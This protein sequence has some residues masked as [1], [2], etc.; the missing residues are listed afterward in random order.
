MMGSHNNIYLLLHIFLRCVEMDNKTALKSDLD[1]NLNFSE[2][3]ILLD[4]DKIIV[5][6][7]KRT[8]FEL[9]INEIKSASVEEGIGIG[10]LVIKTKKNKE[11][12]I[13]YFTKKKAESF[14]KLSL[15]INAMIDGKDP[16]QINLDKKEEEYTNKVG[17]L[18]WLIH[19]MKPYKLKISLGVV[20]AL[21]SVALNL[22]P[23]LIIK[24][25]IDNVLISTSDV[26]KGLFGLLTLELFAALAGVTLVSILQNYILTVTGQKVVNDL[27]SRTYDHVMRLS[28]SSIEKISSGRILSRLTTDVGNTQWLMVWGF[29]TIA[30]NVL[31]ILGVGLILFAMDAN[32]AVFILIPV[33]AAIYAL[34][35]YRK[36]SHRIYHRNWRRN[37]DVT[38]AISDTVP[39]YFI[40]KSF[41]KEKFE[42]KRL[43][44]LLNSLYDSQVRV[45]KMNQ[46]YWPVLGFITAFST[47]LIWWVGGNQVIAGSIQLGVITAFVFYMSMF[48]GPINNLSNIIPFIQQASTSGDRLRE[49]LETEPTIT[50]SKHPRKPDLNAGISFNNVNFGYEP[51][52][53]VL[54]NINLSIAKGEKVAIVGKSGSGKSTISKLILRF[55]D[56]NDGAMSINGVN[57]KEIE[58]GYLRDRIAYVPQD[59]ILFDNTVAYNVAYGSNNH[60][61]AK[62]IIAACKAAIIHD[63]IMKLPSAYDTNLNER[64]SSLSG[65]QKQRISIA[66]AVVKIPDIVILDE[67]TSNLDVNSE[68]EIY[69]ALVNLMQG[70]TSIMITHNAHEVMN[71]DRI[72]VMENG[73]ICESGSPEDLLRKKGNF[74][75]MFKRQISKGEFKKE[76]ADE[77]VSSIYSYIDGFILDPKRITIT[78]GDRESIVDVVALGKKHS[79]LLPKLPF[80]ISNPN[81]VI[82]YKGGNELLFVDDITALDHESYKILRKAITMNNFKPAI[83]TIRKILIRGDELEWHVGTEY[84][85]TIINTKG[86]RNISI[87]GSTISLTDTF[88]NIYE[89]EIDKLD[90]KSFSI[91]SESI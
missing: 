60:I 69:K 45:T 2:E 68:R 44:A 35:K 47:I 77:S 25:L 13:A 23:P 1:H 28:S 11:L 12:E 82:F 42:N 78:T 87:D 29:P 16:P 43:S 4:K 17:T 64:G 72:I 19:F 41:S 5:A 56:V 89:I 37:A 39:N 66:R 3:Q 67:S 62:E 61:G 81:A 34:I 14:R 58:L 10:R 83:R 76:K 32:L 80:P 86:R 51:M 71:A 18:R 75:R 21:V 70:K 63:E 59:V 55:Y 53:H 54:K 36:K 20:L 31:T 48:Y 33:P 91:I 73:K 24:A 57:V 46:F 26:S 88:D 74:Y 27:K 52:L 15:I 40:V 50:N 65:G 8:L 79:G 85:N 30:T 7:D 22:V 6:K 49:L 38:A 9:P 90:Q 84:G